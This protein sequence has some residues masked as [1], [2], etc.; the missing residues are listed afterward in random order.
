MNKNYPRTLVYTNDQYGGLNMT[1]V[2]DIMGIEKIKFFFMHLR[3]QDTTAQLLLISMQ[4][5]QMECG[6]GKLFFNLPYTTF[7]K[8]AT[9][10]WCKSL[11]EYC[12]VRE[13]EFDIGLNVVPPLQRKHD[14]FI[15]DILVK[16]GNFST[17][18][19]IGMNK[20]RQHL[21]LLMLSDVTDF[22]GKRLLREIQEGKS[23]RRSNYKFCPQKPIK[24]WETL[25]TSKVCP[26]LNMILQRQPLGSWVHESHQLW[27][28]EYA[29]ATHQYLR[30]ENRVFVKENTRF[31]LLVNDGMEEEIIFN[32]WADVGR[33]KKGNPVLIASQD[34]CAMKTPHDDRSG[35]SDFRK[36]ENMWGKIEY[37]VNE[38][39]FESYCKEKKCLVA[40][41]GANR[42]EEG[43]QAWIIAS[44]EGVPMIR[45]RGRV[46]YARDDALLAVTTFMSDMAVTKD[47]NFGLKGAVAIYTDSVNSIS[48]M[49]ETLMPSTKNAL[50]NN[51][52][53]KIELKNILRTSTVPFKL[54]HVRAHQD[55]K[56]PFDELPIEAQLNCLADAHAGGV[57]MDVDCG[58][59]LEEAL[60]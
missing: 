16:Y 11:W 6:S 38:D 28:W 46:N 55:D 4:T 14:H 24:A 26:I 21:Q 50:E 22:R 40:T 29:E 8:L 48:D 58:I 52:D 17:T 33:D 51:I 47:I 37:L 35:I 20:Y 7:S 23:S 60:F 2:Y 54:I 41:D 9:K 49:K 34:K 32:K 5:T 15:M 19:L 30:C 39:D 44:E 45:G 43:A 3:R 27:T 42:D 36:Y 12:D 18:E 13:M 1:H 10:T 31:G 59:H 25:W 53:M 57:Y 56:M